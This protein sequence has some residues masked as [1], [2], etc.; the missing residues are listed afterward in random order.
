MIAMLLKYEHA[1][2]CLLAIV[3]GQPAS[4]CL[5]RAG[6]AIAGDLLAKNRHPQ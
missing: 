2:S 4:Q 1:S 3:A 6:L 5:L